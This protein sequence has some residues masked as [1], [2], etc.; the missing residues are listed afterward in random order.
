M[1]DLQTLINAI[2]DAQDG[3][4]ITS[5]YHNTIK[6]ALHAIVGQLGAAAPTTVTRTL[7]PNFTAIAGGAAPWALGIGSAADAGPPSTSGFMPLNL[8]DGV[9]IQTMTTIGRKTNAGPVGNVNLLIVPIGGAGTGTILIQIDLSVAG[10]PFTL[11][12]TPNV[13]GLTSSALVSLQTVQ[14]LQFKYFIEAQV[15]SPQGTTPA[16]VVI[17]AL[18]VGY[19]I[20]S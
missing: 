12:G 17:N 9:V 15:F 18:Q 2:P 5:N 8:P 4:V 7:P 6:A 19:T 10:D 3:N 14:N 13:P 11:T 16:S 1:P 20:T